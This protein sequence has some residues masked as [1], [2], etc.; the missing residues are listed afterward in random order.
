[1]KKFSLLVALVIV[2][3]TAIPAMAQYSSSGS[4]GAAAT[5]SVL[6]QGDPVEWADYHVGMVAGPGISGCPDAHP[7]CGGN[8]CYGYDNCCC[9]PP[10]CCCLKKI[11]RMLDC[12]LPCHNSCHG[13]CLFGNC[14][15]HLFQHG[16]CG[17]C[18]VGCA[19]PS[20]SSP[21]GYPGAGD[22]FI[23]DPI[24]PQP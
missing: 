4:R 18:N 20:C 2:A 24:Q 13:G 11:A 9:P 3:L 17:G 10:L 15:P 8:V 21:I 7:T 1:M 14:R 23:D 12:L 22:P 5:R 16:C 19:A 6:K